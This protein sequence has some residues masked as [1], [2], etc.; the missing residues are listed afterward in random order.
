[1]RIPFRSLWH[2]CFF[3]GW[4]FANPSP[5]QRDAAPVRILQCSSFVTVKAC[6]ELRITLAAQCTACKGWRAFVDPSPKQRDAAPVRILWCSSFVTVKACAELRITLATQCTACK[7]WRAFVAPSPTPLPFQGRRAI[8]VEVEGST[9]KIEWAR[10]RSPQKGRV[11]GRS[12]CIVSPLPAGGEGV[13][14]IASPFAVGV[15]MKRFPKYHRRQK[16]NNSLTALVRLGAGS[17]PGRLAFPELSCVQEQNN[18]LS[19]PAWR[20]PPKCPTLERE[21]ET[22]A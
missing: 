2:W 1:M 9:P 17:L 18:S 15:G 5:K 12:P 13:G 16:Q 11:Q 20:S 21:G 3:G 8:I 14:A 22:I 4:G 6:A 19:S 7:G 10:G